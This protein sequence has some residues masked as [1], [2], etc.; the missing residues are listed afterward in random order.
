[1]TQTPEK[2][3]R[4]K[5]RIERLMGR[6]VANP[7]VRALNRIGIGTTLAT[8]L[9]TIGRKT[10]RY[11]RVPVAATFD[12]TGAWLISQHGTRSGWTANITADPRVRIRHGAHWRTGTA[13]LEPGD[14]VDARTRTFTS[15]PDFA[16]MTAATFRALQSAPISVRITFTRNLADPPQGSR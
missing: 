4:R 14:D 1:M 16:A 2:R 7:T 11:R 10:G 6:Y 13:R 9:E 5:F 15:H 3:S 8:E 12:D